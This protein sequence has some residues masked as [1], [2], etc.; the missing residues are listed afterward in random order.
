[1]KKSEGEK[2]YYVTAFNYRLGAGPTTASEG[3]LGA[4]RGAIAQ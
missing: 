4:D 3:P 2:S 1:M